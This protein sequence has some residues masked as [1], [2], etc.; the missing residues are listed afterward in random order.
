LDPILVNHRVRWVISITNPDGHTSELR[1]SLPIHVLHSSLLSEAKA[2]TSVSRRLLFGGDS[3]LTAEEQDLELPSYNAHIRDRVANMFLPDSAT[4]RI[5]N[6]WIHHGSHPPVTLFS[7]NSPMLPSHV[8][9]TFTPLEGGGSPSLEWVNSELLLSLQNPVPSRAPSPH[10]ADDSANSSR[11]ASRPGSRAG[12]GPS[13]RLHSRSGSPERAGPPSGTDESYLHNAKNASRHPQGV[14]E[15]SMK[16]LTSLSHSMG[17]LS[18]AHSQ[19]SV[20]T[21]SSLSMSPT[22]NITT[23]QVQINTDAV[24]DPTLLQRAYTEVP[25]YGVALRGFLGGVPPL[26]STNGLPSYEA[27][28]AQRTQTILP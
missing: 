8:D 12:S 15:A 13:S 26:T 2:F 20:P 9:G 6:P 4:I 18:R 21:L 14:F 17:W 22:D 23:T 24:T 5:T 27:S 3:S 16:P 19:P 28:E 25:G 10:S 11:H 1:C 7:A